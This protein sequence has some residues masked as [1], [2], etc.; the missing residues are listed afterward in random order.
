M[1]NARCGHLHHNNA[2]AARRPALIR[3]VTINRGCFIERMVECS[4]FGCRAFLELSPRQSGLA[5][6]CHIGS[7][8]RAEAK[9]SVF[10]NTP[11]LTATFPG[12]IWLT[13]LSPRMPEL[14]FGFSFGSPACPSTGLPIGLARGCGESWVAIGL[15]LG[16][17]T[18]TRSTLPDFGPRVAHAILPISD[19]GFRLGYALVRSSAVDAPAASALAL[20]AGSVSAGESHKVEGRAGTSGSPRARL[21]STICKSKQL[22]NLSEMRRE[23]KHNPRMPGT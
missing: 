2:F 16:E 8:A 17:T 5:G 23:S 9:Q 3:D 7:D 22:M 11:A 4:L 15:G 19:K 6:Y 14:L 13:E 20:S 1:G 12:Q 21:R 10:C 18:D